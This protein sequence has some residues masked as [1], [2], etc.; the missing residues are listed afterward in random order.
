MCTIVRT[1]TNALGMIGSWSVGI[2]RVVLPDIFLLLNHPCVVQVA[3]GD[4]SRTFKNIEKGEFENLLRFVESKDIA[5]RNKP[6][7]VRCLCCC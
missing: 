2:V 3:Y 1:K 5:V 7:R 6:V 4:K